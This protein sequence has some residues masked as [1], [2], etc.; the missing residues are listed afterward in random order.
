MGAW[1]AAVAVLALQAAPADHHFKEQS[2]NRLHVEKTLGGDA[3]VQGDRGEI[4]LVQAGDRLGSEGLVVE[5]VR[6]GCIVLKG[7]GGRF[8]I[9]IDAPSMPRS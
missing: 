4:V 7:K 1:P 5:R 8:S 2:A 9:C 3:V 6:D